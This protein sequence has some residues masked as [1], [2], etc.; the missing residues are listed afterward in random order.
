MLPLGWRVHQKVANVVRQEIDA[1]GGQEFLLPT[2]HPAAIWKES[3]RWD[4][5]IHTGDNAADTTTTTAATNRIRIEPRSSNSA[6]DTSGIVTWS[7][8]GVATRFAWG[9][10]IPDARILDMFDCGPRP[11][12]RTSATTTRYCSGTARLGA[13]TRPISTDNFVLG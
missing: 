9:V 3:G 6:T 8:V 5:E 1:I 11:I 2:M 12:R 13:A 7:R 4:T 10:A